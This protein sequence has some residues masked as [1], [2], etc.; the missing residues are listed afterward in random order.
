V[1]AA[2]RLEVRRGTA[3]AV[4]R[5]PLTEVAVLGSLAAFAASVDAGPGW[6]ALALAAAAVASALHS[7]GARG[8][9]RTVVQT[10]TVLTAAGA[11][12]FL[13]DW[14]Q[15]QVETWVASG[16][17]LGAV[18]LVVLVAL[19]WLP[20]STNDWAVV[21]GGA[22][23]LFLLGATVGNFSETVDRGVAGPWVAGG[24]AVAS[25]C[26]VS[27]VRPTRWSG[28]RTVAAVFGV[29]AAAVLLDA[30]GAGA[31][32][33]LAASVVVGLVGTAGVVAVAIAERGRGWNPPLEG[34]ALA[35]LAGAAVAGTQVGRRGVALFL[36]LLGTELLAGGTVRRRPM[37]LYFAP[38]TLCASWLLVASDVF[39][40]GPTW[41]T[42]PAGA[43]VLATVE[44]ARRQRRSAGLAP[45]NRPLVLA[46]V[47]GMVLLVVTPLV[48]IVQLGLVH[49]VGSVALGAALVVW[50]VLTRVRRRLVAGVVTTC[51]ALGLLVVVP[52]VDI[53]RRASGPLVWLFVAGAGLVAIMVA[54][55]FERRGEG[56]ADR[57][58]RV[59]AAVEGWE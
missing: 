55:V 30:V 28:W 29:G 18:L 19:A 22:G 8:F 39:D 48:Q 35:G 11:W 20:G 38:V 12:A 43:T 45:S 25:A 9:W 21:A 34:V 54:A 7:V 57:Q 41:F 24:L 23:L 6:S 3:Q 51:T 27:L 15:W 36:L 31:V 56:T 42:V 26:A 49:V 17:V 50:G 52:M 5:Q 40:H 58:H 2:A 46:E 1:A 59:R 14:Q 4:W 47:V 13:G 10:V 33:L 16:A 53:A 44:L 37:L 32:E